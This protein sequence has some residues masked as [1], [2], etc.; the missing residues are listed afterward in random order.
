MKARVERMLTIEGIE[1]SFGDNKVLKG[2]DLKV[3]RDDVV[4]LIGPN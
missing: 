3:N 1:K 4:A 2:I